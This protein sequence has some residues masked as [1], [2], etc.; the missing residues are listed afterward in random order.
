MTSARWRSACRS[1]KPA[2][3]RCWDNENRAGAGQPR[4]E[5]LFTALSP[6]NP[7]P[8]PVGRA[9]KILYAMPP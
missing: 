8:S 7:A 3:E 9:R 4:P 6:L 1:S 2:S 5:L